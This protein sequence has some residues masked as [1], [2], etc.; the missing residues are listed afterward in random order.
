[1]MAKLDRTKDNPWVLKTPPGKSEY[2]MHMGEKDGLPV[3]VCTVGKTVLLYDARCI[4]DLYSMLKE[5][6][7]WEQ[8]AD[9]VSFLWMQG[10]RIMDAQFQHL[11]LSTKK[12]RDGPLGDVPVFMTTETTRFEGTIKD[13]NTCF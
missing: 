3:L 6:G 1:M 9:V 10:E 7:D 4:D 11:T 13:T 12:H 5:T 8:D 2:T